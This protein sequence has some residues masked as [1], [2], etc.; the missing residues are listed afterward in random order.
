MRKTI[1]AILAVAATSGTWAAGASDTSDIV[2]PADLP[3]TLPLRL[4]RADTQPVPQEQ[5]TG[6]ARAPAGTETTTDAVEEI[7]VTAQRRAERLQDVPISISVIGGASLDMSTAEGVT[8]SLSRVPGVATTPALQGGGTQVTVRGVTAA[9]PLF[10][11]SNP[12]GYYLDSIPFGLV[13][14]AIVPDS[15]AYDLERIEVLRGPQG[16]LYG[17]SALNGVMRVLTRNANLDDLEFKVRTSG[18]ATTDGGENYRGDLAF[19]LPIVAGRLAARAVVG[20]QDLSGWMDKPTQEDFNDGEVRNLRLKVNGALTDNLSVGLSG[21]FSRAEYGG[22]SQG[23][24]DRGNSF[25]LP[26]PIASDYDA[27]NLNLTYQLPAISISSATSLLEYSTGGDLDLGGLL[28]FTGLDSD[29]V[30]QEF[31]LN[32]A[33]NESWRW[34]AGAIYRDAEDR[35]LQHTHTSPSAPGSG[36]YEWIDT[37][38][39]AAVFGEVTKVLAGGRVELTGGLRYFEDT[40]HSHEGPVGAEPL[41]RTKADS[42][43]VTPR[44]VV[45]WH[46]NPELSVYTSYSEGFRSG[47]DQFLAAKNALGFGPLKPDKLRNYEIGAKGGTGAG[48]FRYE[49][50]VYFID[51]SDVQ[52]S[53][54]FIGDDGIGRAA[55]TNAGSASGLGVD[56]SAGINPVEGLELG[57]NGSWNDLTFDEDVFSAGQLLFG[58]G[59]RLNNSPEYTAAVSGDYTF[60]I[61]GSGYEGTLSASANYTS[62]QTFRTLLAQLY[63]TVGDDMLFGRASFSIRSPSR[64]TATLFVDNVTDEKGTPIRALFGV[65]DWSV[66]AR[67]RTV[68]LQVEYGF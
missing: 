1:R 60:A 17:A 61:G 42:D 37:S 20:Y 23:N 21:W 65:P 52:Q 24:E 45:T 67:P 13:K 26:E 54:S 33:P 40:V 55:N 59:E 22:P 29:V 15:N 51:W 4:A 18:S 2:M 6:A 5:R 64:W 10:F 34:S 62:E 31:T 36:S 38:E 9:G 53:L 27:Y 8:E 46:P 66:R 48:G 58:A 49:A 3:V 41:F 56:V 68:G 63:M 11:G 25:S 14:S 44:A 19:N 7:I 30:T 50:A 47:F 28:L 43:A 57:I 32:S 39:S 16:T 12:I 35:S